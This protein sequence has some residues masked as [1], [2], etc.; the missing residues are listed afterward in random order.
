MEFDALIEKLSSLSREVFEAAVADSVARTHRS[1]EIEH[2]LLACLNQADVAEC[3][4][5]AAEVDCAVVEQQI[6][7]LLESQATGY[8]GFPKIAP[9]VLRWLYEAWL[10]ASAEFQTRHIDPIH[11]L[12]ALTDN[13]ALWMQYQDRLPALCKL[14]AEKLRTYH[15]SQGEV[16]RQVPVSTAQSASALQTYTTDLTVM[17]EQGRL[18]AVLGRELEIRQVIDVLCRRKQNNAMLIGEAGVG[19]TAVAEGL[20]LAIVADRVPDLL[21]TV[22]LL[23]LDLGALHAGAGVKGEFEKRLKRLI[24]EITQST[25]PIVLFID[26]AHTL[27]GNT[28]QSGA[29]DAANLFKPAL[30]RGNLRTIGATTWSEYKQYFET[31]AALTRRFEVIKIDEP[32]EAQAKIMVRS[33]VEH[34]EAHHGVRIVES[35]IH[36]AVTLSQRYITGR[37]M[38]DKCLSVLDTACAR[39]ALSHSDEPLNLIC[40]RRR[41]TDLRFEQDRLMREVTRGELSGESTE[42]IAESLAAAEQALEILSAR[43]DKE[44]CLIAR[45]RQIRSQMSDVSSD[46]VAVN[47]ENDPKPLPVGNYTEKRTDSE[48]AEVL[49]QLVTLNAELAELQGDSPA[50]YDCVDEH[51]VAAVVGDW[52]GI[53]VGR[54]KQDTFADLMSLESVLSERVTGQAAALSRI[55]R[56]IRAGRAGLTDPARP[57]GIFMLVGP[58]G[59]GKTETALALAEHLY[60]AEKN[61]TVINMSEFKEEHKVSLLLGAPPGYVGY[62]KGGI[63]TEAVRRRPFSVVLL[64]ELE[65]AH[66]SVQEIFYQAFDKGTLKDGEGRDIDFRNTLIVMTSNVASDTIEHLCADDASLPD[67]ES[68][69]SAIQPA[70]RHYFKPAFL[71]RV[72]IIPYFPLT[73]QALLAVAKQQIAK[74]QQRVRVQY[75]A[76]LTF[77]EKAMQH[78]IGACTASDVGARGIADTITQGVL[79]LIAERLLY[80][81]ASR[82]PLSGVTVDINANG[83]FTVILVEERPCGA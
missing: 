28:G 64:D 23:S 22:R 59:V 50:L 57:Q 15:I 65:K 5:E 24:E 58:S 56:T 62:G 75:K 27:I 71:G 78:V 3:L 79:P 72:S 41:L 43:W 37:Q 38:P 2:C 26:E 21:K 60:G 80:A 39:V 67:P 46:S 11:L 8:E 42:A 45:I 4:A 25:Q 16:H 66:V 54:M 53:P 30:A 9:E 13:A 32:D 83:A 47:E 61:L 35:A 81:S 77:S 31:D 14:T 49:A 76:A 63:L 55:S 20:A 51:V 10:I 33:A 40:A 18:D 29:G 36:S 70:L 6:Q 73:S 19:K 34:Y 52:T 44:K 68:L 17:A 48:K 7:S 12:M 74:V 1:V 69:L 82:M